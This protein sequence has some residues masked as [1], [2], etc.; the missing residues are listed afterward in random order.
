M[1]CSLPTRRD[2]HPDR[3]QQACAEIDRCAIWALEC[4]LRLYPKAGLVSFVDTGSHDDMDAGTFLRSAAALTGYF[5]Q[6]A[7]AGA[8]GAG[9]NELKT[10]G[11]AAEARMFAAT[12]G[13]NTHRGAVFTLGL[14]AAAAGRDGFSPGAEPPAA[15]ARR[16]CTRV[17]LWGPAILAGRP[18][19][20][21]SHGA[22]VRT[23]YGAPGARDQAAAGYPV[24]RRH[25]LPAFEAAYRATGCI[26]RAG[27]QGFYATVATLADNNLLYRAGPDGLAHAQQSAREFLAAGGMLAPDGFERA[28]VLHRSFVVRR[29][30]PGGAA[31]LIAATLFLAAA[32]GMVRPDELSWA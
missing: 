25:T 4:E 3:T 21:S 9:F 19:V 18:P 13:V 23:R 22:A 24:L 32:T 1:N 2:P 30:S 15:R 7:A 29:L 10:L 27:L 12:G 6:M 14:L 31:D 5:G 20:D 28:G 11:M 26:E 8:R 16:I 17:G